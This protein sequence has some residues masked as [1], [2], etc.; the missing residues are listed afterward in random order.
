MW[1]VIID[2]E[3]SK[4]EGQRKIAIVTDISRGRGSLARRVLMNAPIFEDADD[5]D[6]RPCGGFL[7]GE[8][9]KAVIVPLTQ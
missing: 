2:V 9:V 4:L 7:A 1:G 3:I 6:E 5:I 8:K